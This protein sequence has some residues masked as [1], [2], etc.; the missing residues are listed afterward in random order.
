[1]SGMCFHSCGRG[2][3]AHNGFT[4]VELLVALGLSVIFIVA[5][6]A[7]ASGFF[8]V[9]SNIHATVGVASHLPE[10]AIWLF[11]GCYNFDN[12]VPQPEWIVK[13]AAGGTKAIVLLGCA[14]NEGGVI[15]GLSEGS[16][17]SVQTEG[18][19]QDI[20]LLKLVWDGEYS[21]I[22]RLAFGK[23]NEE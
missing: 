7:T 17:S 21:T 11:D 3:K 2:N 8:K 5:L 22:I 12:A 16:V 15:S 23:I 18:L 4:L 20:L 6:A 13:S 19:M 9:C 14:D 10:S 1:M